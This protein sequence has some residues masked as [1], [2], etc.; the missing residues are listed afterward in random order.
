MVAITPTYIAGGLEIFI[1]IS[2]KNP[3]GK[4]SL[5][6]FFDLLKKHIFIDGGFC[7]LVD[8]ESPPPIDHKCFY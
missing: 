2:V 4:K 5:K 3:I 6:I 1:R 7:E 8:G